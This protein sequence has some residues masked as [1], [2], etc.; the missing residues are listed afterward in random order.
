LGIVVSGPS[1]TFGEFELDSARFELR[2]NGRVLKLERI[3]LE[4][5]I[6]LVEKDGTVVT[7]Q[8]IVERLW[9]KDVFLDTEHGINTAIRKIRAV[10]RE[11]A[12]QPRFLQTIQRKGYRFLDEPKNGNA[13]IS[14]P[15]LEVVI[16]PPSPA[17]AT[18]AKR[19]GWWMVAASAVVL[20]LLAAAL[21]GFNAGGVRDRWL[22]RSHPAQIQSIAV[23]PLA[24][25]SGDASQE[26]FAEGMTD[27]LITALAKN[28]SLR[29]VSRTSAMQ[30]K[31]VR[32]PLGE[33]ARELGVDGILE[34]SVER[35]GNRVH[36]TVQLIHAPSDT[37]IWAESYDRDLSEVISL[38]SELS[39]TIAKEVKIAV[40]PARPQRNINPEAYDAYLHG[41][42][43]WFNEDT[44]RSQKY[45]EKAIQLQPDYAAAW[46]GLADSYAVRAVAGVSPP[47]AVMGKAEEAA[48]KAIELD[49][50]LSDA[51]NTRAALY[52]FD[53]WDWHS[54][55]AE[56]RRALELNPNHADA[57]HL[58]SYVLIAMQRL[59]EAL[60][61]Q[62]RSTELD[63]FERPW[64][65]GHAYIRMR[66]FDAATNELRLRAEGQPRN[67]LVR[68]L[69]SQAYWLKGMWKESQ[70]E[71]EEGLRLAG[72]KKGAVDAHQAFEKG[73]E[74]AVEQWGVS[75]LKARARK[76]YVSPFDMASQY[77]YL[78]QK[79]ETLRF[80]EEAYRERS[81]WLVFLQNEPIFD[82]LHSDEHYRTIVKKIGLPPAY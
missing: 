57:H 48:R 60:Q 63:P 46:S 27:E 3:P 70:Q 19:S 24:N 16:K 7:R 17:D 65:L 35:S 32:R 79:E 68:F 28:R 6:L 39:Q 49:D 67:G 44:E 1:Y 5:L 12:E 50:S 20:L 73:G 14:A 53:A 9:G 11:D 52:L 80:L 25:L 23:L 34:G 40:S 71:L 26:Y 55:E 21:L 51:H 10:L 56:S 69:L 82:F 64:A 54:A 29:V 62:K 30:Y 66:Q 4:L 45:F 58:Y 2:R 75:D 36:M 33:I 41:R 8:E 77:A 72:D 13:A 15:P 18:P 47:Q 38:P 78:G 81:P 59:D 42:Y 61:E 37:H 43:F 76:K 31:G 22:A 74:R